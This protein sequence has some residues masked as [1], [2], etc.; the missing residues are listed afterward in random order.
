MVLIKLI[1]NLKKK[2]RSGVHKKWR[3]I[4]LLNVDLKVISIALSQKLKK[5]LPDLISSQ[6]MAHAE[7]GR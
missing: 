5:V 4:S 3:T 2:Q 7:S 1:K 6:K